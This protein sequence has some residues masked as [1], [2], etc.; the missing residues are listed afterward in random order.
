V[1][2][3]WYILAGAVYALL[4][5]LA[6]PPFGLWFLTWLAPLPLAFVALSREPR[7]ARMSLLVALGSL[8]LW[9]YELTYIN[10]MTSAGYVPLCVYLSLYTFLFSWLLA[11]CR[12]ALPRVPLVISFPVLWVFVELLRC[13]IVLGG[14]P[15]MQI[16][17]PLVEAPFLATPARLGGMYLV[18][19]LVAGVAGA[20]VDVIGSRPCWRRGVA[21]FAL[22]VLA[23][24]VLSPPSGRAGS[25][26]MTAGLV[27]TNLPQNNK[28]GW[29]IDERLR[30]MARWS[31]L[32]RQAAA[33]SPSPQ[34]IV[35]PETMF[36][37]YFLDDEAVRTLRR[38]GI[39]QPRRLPDGS[40]TRVY[41][42]DFAD[43]LMGLSL[44]LG[45]P[46]IVGAIGVDGLRYDGGAGGSGLKFDARFNSAFMVDQG[47]VVGRYDK[48]AL[49][50]MGEYMPLIGRWKWLQDR[51]LA[52]GGRGMR[53]DLR[54]GTEPVVF[55]IDTERRGVRVVTPICFETAWA[56]QCR[57]LVGREGKRRADVMV[58]LTNDGWFSDSDRGR[59]QHL[60]TARWR[61]VELG[62]PMIRAA[63]TGISAAINADGVVLKRGVD[64][65]ERATDIDG[66]LSVSVPIPTGETTYLRYG[67]L[68]RW[69]A[70]VA[71]SGLAL[72]GTLANVRAWARRR[73]AGST[74][75]AG[76]AALEN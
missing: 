12:R 38:D 16:A 59:E 66:V 10:A 20:I 46:L 4:T 58:C 51:L 6:L 31:S 68:F 60:Q 3:W 11:V 41:L 49:T 26:A 34:L 37:G 57:D 15:W 63:N 56:T 40:E 65:G 69:P 24:A 17:Q 55:D 1:R 8:P 70:L 21:S 74:L 72:A 22:I 42:T 48:V 54:A 27:Q 33:A 45:V 53:F 73:R 2:W 35:W 44:D 32:T 25:V 13:E 52:L 61:C 9:L 36:P 75:P 5:A 28:I 19:F 64:G 7:A 62:T 30:D 76:L 50:P 39:N 47:H 14:Y 18:S 43:N 23:F 67:D 29:T 71:G